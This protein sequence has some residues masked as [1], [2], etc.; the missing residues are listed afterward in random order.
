MDTPTPESRLPAL[1]VRFLQVFVS[2]GRLTE[3]LALNPAWAAA[4]VA[5]AVLMVAQTILIPAEVW[6]TVFREA[7]LQ[8]GNE[9]P[10]G[11]S[12]N[13]NTMRLIGTISGG[14]MYFI[15]A[16]LFSGIV[17][18]IFVFLMGDEGRF[19]QYLAMY[20]HALLIPG[21]VGLLL[22]P[23]RIAQADPRITLNLG[24]FLFF[25]PDGFLLRWATMMD[26][27]QIWAWVVVAVG[28][29]A[30]APQRGVTGAAV[31]LIGV[32]AA[33]AML[34]AVLQPGG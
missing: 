1:P 25:L 24:T 30:I 21:V 6:E 7:A 34:L 27:T 11:F 19:K 12:M 22:V 17:T 31:V 33:F 20:A 9:I 5:G 14:I 10:E 4:L 23:L 29:N 2:P 18:G 13:G 28:A 32:G 15:M 3:S 26:L 16:L 8:R